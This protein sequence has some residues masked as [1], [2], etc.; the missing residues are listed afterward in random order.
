ML[1]P[2]ARTGLRRRKDRIGWEQ[3]T[4]VLTSVAERS[5]M[6]ALVNVVVPV[7]SGEGRHKGRE[8]PADRGL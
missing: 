7:K 4:V 8:G 2:V 6:G 3:A 1:H 5:E